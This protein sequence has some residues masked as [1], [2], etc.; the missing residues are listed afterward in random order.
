[1]PKI[2][3]LSQTSYFPAFYQKY[4]H[5]VLLMENHLLI[6]K[7]VTISFRFYISEFFNSIL[8]YVFHTTY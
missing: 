8:D 2:P 7:V 4:N 3:T 5:M 6:N 1:M